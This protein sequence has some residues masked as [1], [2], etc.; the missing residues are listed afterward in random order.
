[1]RPWQCVLVL[2][3]AGWV[4]SGCAAGQ[5]VTLKGDTLMLGE[6]RHVMS[7]SLLQRGLISETEE[8]RDRSTFLEQH[9][10]TEAQ[11]DAG[12]LQVVRVQIYWNNTVSGV[13]RDQLG[14]VL[15]EE[16][17]QLEPGNIVE[18]TATSKVRRVRARTLAEGSCYYGNVPVGELVELMGGLS[19]VGP[20]GSASLYCKGIELDGWHRPRTFWHKLPDAVPGAGPIDKPPVEVPVPSR[21]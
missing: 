14:V 6:V 19:L 4:L 11:L 20:R 21:G 16:G 3:S 15:A 18:F 7:R 1:M 17:L 8:L 2:G 13:V 10:W 5:G 9:G 12:R